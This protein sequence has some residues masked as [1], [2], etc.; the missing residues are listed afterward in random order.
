MKVYNNIL[1]NDEEDNEDEDENEDEESDS[2][3]GCLQDLTRNL[4][5][6]S[7]VRQAMVST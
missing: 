6:T 2:E 1:L 5:E 3:I 7:K 4:K